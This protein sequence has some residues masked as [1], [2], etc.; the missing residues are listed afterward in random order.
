MVTVDF[1][2]CCTAVIMKDFGES[3]V[4]EGGD[5][6]Y[7]EKQIESYINKT[8]NI[9]RKYGKAM[10]VATTNSEQKVANKVLRK[11]GFK[12]SKWSSKNQHKNTKIRL[13]YKSLN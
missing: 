12:Y 11:L 1:P 2:A 9:Q 8:I 7:T 13:W 5:K 4:A 10:V 3:G 6:L